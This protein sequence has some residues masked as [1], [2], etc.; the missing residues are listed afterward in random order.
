MADVTKFNIQKHEISCR[1][2]NTIIKYVRSQGRD[3]KKLLE[4]LPY[5]EKY[6]TD[7]NNWISRELENEIF[8]RV[9]GIFG[10]DDKVL[11]KIGLASEKLHSLGFLDYALRLI[12][13]P[14][15]IIK[16][17]PRFSK[18]FSKIH[19]LE[20]LKHN[21]SSATIKY[22]R[23]PGY[24]EMNA[25]DCYFTTG[26]ISVFPTIWGS[27][28]ARVHEET[29][30]VRIDKK[31]ILDGKFYTID[32][33]QNVV[34]RDVIKSKLNIDKPRVIGRLNTDGTFKL[35]NT[36]YGAKSCLRH[37]TWSP[38]KLW[39]KKIFYDLFIKPKVLEATMEE[40]QRENDLILKKYEEIYQVNMEIQKYYIDTIN[41][42]VRAIDAKDHYT[43]NHSINV[44]GVAGIIAEKM[45][46]E[47]KRIEAIK[48]AC[49]LHDIGKIGVKDS[50]LLKPGKLTLEEWEEIK[51]HPILGSEIIKPLKFLTDVAKLVRQDH[52]RW[53][54][55]GYP[56]GL[57]KEEIDLG[58]RI[59]ALADSYDAMITGR[60]YRKKPLTKAEAI[61]EIKRCTGS[62]FDPKVVKIFLQTIS[63]K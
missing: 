55:K 57:K 11:L 48:N 23:K 8:R 14:H 24:D 19:A 2:T 20:A 41:A 40:M 62:Q 46:L 44:C 42:L 12:G 26:V 9:R 1:V 45:G 30:A 17:A 49:K 3:V 54:G 39:L 31:G 35:G 52:E 34:E 6:L 16:N 21:S 50:I 61:E 10:D 53:D 58:A 27:E 13:R 32:N 18:Y 37:L 5:D 47:P 15:L 28:P 60:V 63:K 22:T 33:K 59:I 51:K 25:D 7:T 36:L 56:D 38:R 29:C 4:G 43:Q